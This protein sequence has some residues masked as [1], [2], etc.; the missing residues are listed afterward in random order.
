MKT[1]AGNLVAAVFI[2][3]GLWILPGMAWAQ[4]LDPVQD[5]AGVLVGG[6][7]P[8]RPATLYTT[9]EDESEVLKALHA[10]KGE[11]DTYVTF[12]TGSAVAFAIMRLPLPGLFLPDGDL[13]CQT[14]FVKVYRNASCVPTV[15]G[16]FPVCVPY[17]FG[18]HTTMAYN[19]TKKCKVGTG[20]CVEVRQVLWTRNIYFD[21]QCTQL[22]STQNGF[23]S[24]CN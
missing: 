8:D 16:T 21:N 11:E 20:Y 5:V 22:I 23:D 2:C 4:E 7:S 18:H 12:I 17:L 9:V 1:T 24:M 15:T 14:M 19:Q 3:F 6:A 10:T 13:I